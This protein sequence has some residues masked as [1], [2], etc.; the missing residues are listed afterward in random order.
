M[1]IKAKTLQTV[2][3]RILTVTMGREYE[4]LGI[5]ADDYRILDDIKNEFTGNDPVLV[6]A[7]CFEIIDPLEPDFW[8]CET[9]NNGERYCYPPEWKEPGFF[10]DY[11]D[12]IESVQKQF[13]SDLRKYYPSTWKERNKRRTSA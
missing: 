7:E 5:E 1:K 11:H 12:R 6:D 2:D 8:V 4:V 10:E 9:G 3:G 13:W